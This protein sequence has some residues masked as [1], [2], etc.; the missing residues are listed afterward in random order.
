MICPVCKTDIPDESSVCPACHADLNLTRVMP[1]LTGSWCSACGALVP[2]GAKSC[3][4]CGTPLRN[5]G[6]ASQVASRLPSLDEKPQTQSAETTSVM[7]RIESAIPA[8]PN[9]QDEVLYGREHLPRTRTFLLAALASLLIV[10]GGIILITHP[11]D[12]T[13]TDTRATTAAD[14]STAGY[15]GEVERL[16]GQDK[17]G[18][19]AISVLSADEQTYLDLSEAYTELGRLS[20]SADELEDELDATATLGT[21]DERAQGYED[22]QA[23]SL[24]ISNLATS[25]SNI[26]V[27]TGTYVDDRANLATLASWLRNRIEAIEASWERSAASDDPAADASSILA[28]MA[29]NRTSDGSEAY[30]NLFSANYEDW[31]PQEK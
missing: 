4:K 15:P 30:V 3:P 12:P 20:E 5:L 6:K 27:S 19:A 9:P 21:A 7:T 31:M 11:W 29:G 16:T 25:I 17:T 23:L 2:E 10:G 24:A 28:P 26:N 13:L 18:A 14:V 1:K 8:E 22:A